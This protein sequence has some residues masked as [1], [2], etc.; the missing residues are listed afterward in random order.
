M[1]LK[2]VQFEPQ[3]FKGELLLANGYNDFF[4]TKLKKLKIFEFLIL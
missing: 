4:K 3:H 1:N 2:R